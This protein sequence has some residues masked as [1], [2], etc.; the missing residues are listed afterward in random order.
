MA[1]SGG[2]D[3]CLTGP[4]RRTPTDLPAAFRSGANPLPIPPF[5]PPLLFLFDQ[6][7]HQHEPR[8]VAYADD[9]CAVLLSTQVL[10]AS[11]QMYLGHDTM[12]V[13]TPHSQGSPATDCLCACFALHTPFEGVVGSFIYY[14]DAPP[15]AHDASSPRPRRC[16]QDSALC[17]AYE[18][19]ELVAAI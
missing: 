1:S 18:Q 19:P 14:M 4:E 9:R 17:Q 11:P 7:E 10:Q 6:K 5:P 8:K 13:S 16:D 3:G 2:P 15:S 12:F